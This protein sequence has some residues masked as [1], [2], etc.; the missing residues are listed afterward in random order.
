MD[1]CNGANKNEILQALSSQMKKKIT[2]LRYFLSL[3]FSPSCILFSTF[4]LLLLG[5]KLVC[6]YKTAKGLSQIWE[7]CILLLF[8]FR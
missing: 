8:F 1:V 6:C 3:K 7:I 2:K 4:S 5:L